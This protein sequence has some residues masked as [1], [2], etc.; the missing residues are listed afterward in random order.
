MGVD[1]D[2]WELRT[3]RCTITCGP[4]IEIASYRGYRTLFSLVILLLVVLYETFKAL[5][6]C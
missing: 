1:L 6:L 5:L 4:R 2:E 3:L